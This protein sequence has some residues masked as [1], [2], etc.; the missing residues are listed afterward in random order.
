MPAA[1]RTTRT[2]PALVLWRNRVLVDS[3]S[4]IP[5]LLAGDDLEAFAPSVAFGGEDALPADDQGASGFVELDPEREGLEQLPA[6]A[7]ESVPLRFIDPIFELGRVSGDLRR[8]LVRALAIA[9]WSEATRFCSECGR[10]LRWET[11]GRVKIC[12][13]AEPHRHWPRLDPSAIMLVSDGERMLL[14]RQARWPE[15]MY[16]TLAGFVDQGETVEEAVVREV[17][18]EAGI[19][20]GRVTYFGSE[21][22]PFPRSLMLGF[23]AEATSY[24]IVRGD[25][26]EDVRWFTLDE[27]LAL[28]RKLEERM[29][30]ADTIARRLIATWLRERTGRE[31]SL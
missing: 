1:L 4:R 11:P 3:R 5:H 20:V 28:Q 6:V 2:P 8:K 13:N 19:G 18:E 10:P 30:H 31:R 9:R 24:D 16:S 22:W 17:F 25:E 29:P 21:P 26:L 7:L 15:G 12:E 27:G 14:G 23:F